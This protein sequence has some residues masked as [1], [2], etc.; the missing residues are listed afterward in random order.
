M[1]LNLSQIGQIALAVCDVDRAEAFY[2]EKL[3]LRKL[4]RFGGQ[5]SA[6][7]A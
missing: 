3:G 4:Y 7:V 5:C 1:F 6:D 2:R